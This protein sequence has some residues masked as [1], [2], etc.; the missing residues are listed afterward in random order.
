MSYVDG[1]V[2]K[3]TTGVSEHP[4]TGDIQKALGE[5]SGDLG[6][7]CTSSKINVFAKYKPN[8]ITG[9]EQPSAS[10]LANIKYGLAAI[11]TNSRNSLATMAL[12]WTYRGA[13]APYY[14]ELDFDGYYNG[15]IVPFMQANGSSLTIDL[16]NDLTTPAVFYMLMNDGA[17][18]NKAFAPGSGIG[19]ASSQGVPSN[20]LTY[21]IAVEDLGFDKGGGSYVSIMGCALGLVIFQG[22]TYKAEIFATQHPVAHLSTRDNDM[23]NIPLNSLSLGMGNYTAVACA[24]TTSGLTYYLPVYD[25]PSYPARFP[26]IVGGL[27]LYKQAAIGL[28]TAKA[29]SSVNLIRTTSDN[30]YVTMRFYNNSGRTLSIASGSNPKFTLK[31]EFSGSIVINGQTSPT[32]IDRTIANGKAYVTTSIALPS[33][34]TITVA[35]GSYAELVFLV[36]NIWSTNGTSSGQMLDSGSVTIKP[37]LYFN[38]DTEYTENIHRVLS[39]TYGS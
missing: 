14:R 22:T 11:A 6:V 17:L 33:S 13:N 37:R 5:S 28:G 19:P 35:D 1:L 30:V 38:G 29:V 2:S 18:A 31:V 25:D 7:L 15:A 9:Y 21:C 34:G 39:A 12:G 27:D 8:E 3:G 4:L 26:L 32:T 10:A 20:R 36:P 24:K 23:F 16:V